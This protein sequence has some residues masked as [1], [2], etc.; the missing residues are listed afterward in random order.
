MIFARNREDMSG[1]ETLPDEMLL[2][3]L[4]HAIHD[5]PTCHR[6]LVLVCWR[7][8]N[9][10]LAIPYVSRRR[11]MCWISR[12]DEQTR[13]SIRAFVLRKMREFPSRKFE[14]LVGKHGYHESGSVR[15]DTDAN[16]CSWGFI[17]DGE[18]K[19][20]VCVDAIARTLAVTLRV[21]G[22]VSSAILD[23][24]DP[25]DDPHWVD[26]R[27]SMCDV[28]RLLRREYRIGE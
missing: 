8:H 24:D 19:H 25:V 17:R 28:V 22:R 4:S 10:A 3:V 9:V 18:A 23:L 21:R 2:T 20:S 26:E 14:R 6:S 11:K 1:F 16:S 5:L 7:W 15:I 27:S 12:E 13:Q